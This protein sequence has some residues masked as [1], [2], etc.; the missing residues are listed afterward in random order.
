M[1]EVAVGQQT[2]EGMAILSL[3]ERS[4]TVSLN[5]R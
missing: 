3:D 4:L 5:P 1:F 2:Y